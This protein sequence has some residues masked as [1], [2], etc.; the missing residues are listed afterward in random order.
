MIEI[1]YIDD[2]KE[3]H[4]SVTATAMAVTATGM[5]WGDIQ[6]EGLGATEEEA[7]RELL[8]IVQTLVNELDEMLQEN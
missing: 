3:K 8:K 5:G 7:K 1:R 4:Q 6:L 2:K